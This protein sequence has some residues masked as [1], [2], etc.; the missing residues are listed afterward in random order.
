MSEHVGVRDDRTDA[1][2]A[3]TVRRAR[4]AAVVA[5][6][7]YVG[8]LVVF[9]STVGAA[10]VITRLQNRQP[11]PPAP[12]DL[13]NL[14]RVDDRVWAS[15][16]PDPQHYAALA[17]AGVTFIVDLRTGAADDRYQIDRTALQNLEIGYARIPVRDGHVPGEHVVRRILDLV[18]RQHGIVLV[19]CGAGVGRSSTLA[20]GYLSYQRRDI[21]LWDT[22]AL[23]SVTIEQAWFLTTGQRH[24][25]IR[26]ASEA[27][28]LP[29]RTWSRI[30]SVL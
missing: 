4:Q 3:A 30:R 18:Q 9:H 13:E 10:V 14:R 28:D 17:D 16:Q 19:H 12:I 15:G 8:A 5:L 6:M 25:L 20:A 21:S 11:D 7:T 23:G 24:Q 1:R 26:R 2:W 27:I 22:L 29:R